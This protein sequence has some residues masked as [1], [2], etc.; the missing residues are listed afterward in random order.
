MRISAHLPILKRT[1]LVLLAV[2]FVDIG[3]MIYCI[4]NRISYSSSFNIF[5][6]VGGIFLL[7]GSLKAV[8]IIRWF[9]FIFASALASVMFLLPVMTPVDLMYVEFKVAP[10]SSALGM[11]SFIGALLLLR[12]LSTQLSS[13]PVHE[14]LV[15]SGAKVRSSTVPLAVGVALSVVLAAGSVWVQRTESAKRAIAQAKAKYGANYRYHVSSLRYQSTSEGSVV[16]GVVTV[17]SDGDVKHVAFGSRD[18]Q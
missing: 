15:A 18:A 2:G 7:R 9:A 8:S 10:V 12:W 3:V 1:G 14:A 4:V 5:A 6:V 11:L 16:S 17:W 13:P